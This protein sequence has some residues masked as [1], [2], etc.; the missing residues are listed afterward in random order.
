MN[1]LTSCNQ[2]FEFNV[3][4][5]VLEKR[6]FESWKTL[7]FGLRKSWKV[8]EKNHLNVCTNPEYP[9]GSLKIFALIGNFSAMALGIVEM[10]VGNTV[11]A[12]RE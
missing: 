9:L 5:K 7:E 8:P 4:W 10:L 12:G 11:C 2:C 6:I 3:P 1:F